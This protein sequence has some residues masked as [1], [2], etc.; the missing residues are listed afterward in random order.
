M[1]AAMTSD[2]VLRVEDRHLLEGDSTFVGN[3]EVPDM[4]EVVFV[5][6]PH[7]H[8]E[9]VAID[10]A[11]AR[12]MPGVIDVVSAGDLDLRPY[13][14]G[15]PGSP[16]GT[17]RQVLAAARVRF[18]GEP[19][20][21]IVAESLTQASDAAAEVIVDYEPLDAVIDPVAALTDEVLLF[22]EVGTNLMLESNGGDGTPAAVDACDVVIEA[23]FVNQRVAPA[24]IEG[25]AAVALW[26]DAGRLVHYASCQGAHP[27]RAAL[28]DWH[29]LDESAVR[30]ITQDVGGSFGSKARPYTEELVLGL[31]AKR[32][33]RAVR[34]T[35]GRSDDM[36]GLGHSRAQRQTIRLGGDRDGT[37]RALDAQIL[38]ECGAYPVSGGMLG[39]ITAN[40]LPGPYALDSTHWAVTAVV[41]NATPNVAYRGAGRPEAAALLDRAV[42]LYALEVGVDPAE[43]RRRSLRPAEDLPFTSYSGLTYDSGDYHDALETALDIADYTALRA[44]QAR[45]REAREGRLLGIGLCSFIDRTATFPG[46][47]FGSVML[48]ADGSLRVL[49]GSSP[50]GQGHYTTWAMLVSERTGVAMEQIE[51]VHGDTDLVPRG[52]LTGGSRSAQLAGSAVAEATD[53]LVAEASRHAA[54][55]LEAAPSDV[56]LDTQTA[57]FHVAGAPASQSVGWIEIAVESGGSDD[58][59]LRCEADFVSQGGSVPYGTYLAVVEVD[60]ETGD[61]TLE[62]LTTVDDAGTVI[63][64][65]IALGQVHG[66]AAQGVGQALYEEFQYDAW[67]TPLTASLL[68]YTIPSA[69]ELPSFDSHLTE[70]PSPNN[71]LGAKGIGESGTIGATPA[72]QNAVIDALSHLGV[73]HID[74]PLTPER[75]WRA[76]H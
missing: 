71:P 62:R 18:V 60:T 32:A 54:N 10:T 67:G 31:L 73:K 57:R 23:R 15:L 39:Q 35:P 29:G 72:V 66:G 53:A 48:N 33:G 34:W 8:A 46:S 4:L 55:L 19:V 43:V 76:L 69:A 64:P 9:I 13:A 16:E 45:R 6:S 12:R 2:T 42:D 7:A 28:A 20:A 40:L 25:R 24:P 41:T 37:L 5:V 26:D 58:S 75:V 47:E 74:L 17:D 56:V 36:V 1:F 68:D 59:V 49:T 70:H 44:E 51:V 27:Y 50:Y 65:T 61:V 38:V 21:A 52:G 14:S 30:V 3:V 22:P 63:S 11:A